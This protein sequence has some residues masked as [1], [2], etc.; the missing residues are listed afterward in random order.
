M[1]C[2]TNYPTAELFV[3]GKSQGRITKKADVRQKADGGRTM[4][5]DEPLID[6]YRLRWNDVKYEPGELRVVVY[7]ADGKK[8][9]EAVRRTAG[10]P[11]HIVLEPQTLDEYHQHATLKADG[12][13]MMFF[14]VSVV[15]SEGNLCPEAD[16]KIAI[17][18]EGAAVFRGIC[19]G[20]ATSFEVFTN[21]EMHVFK[22]QLVVGIQSDG[23]RGRITLTA[24]SD[25]LPKAVCSNKAR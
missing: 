21:P 17:G 19:N 23:T 15:D 25:G 18:V 6:R 14:T 24:T 3:N 5:A 9:G 13:D 22:G 2:Y 7:D 1:F 8:R 10:A 20:D 4:Q 16:N 11:H 12:E